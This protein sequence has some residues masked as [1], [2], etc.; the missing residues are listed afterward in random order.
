MEEGRGDHSHVRG[1]GG[2]IVMGEGVGD[3]MVSYDVPLNLSKGVCIL[4]WFYSYSH[5]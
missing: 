4:F 3:I 1:G 5:H 2:D